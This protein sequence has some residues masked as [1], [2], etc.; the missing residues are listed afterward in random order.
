MNKRED[1]RPDLPSVVG[2]ELSA[3]CFVRDYVELHF[4]GPVLRLLGDVTVKNDSETKSPSD[5]GF[6]DWLCRN[7]GRRVAAVGPLGGNEIELKFHGN[8]IIR[9]EGQN[10]GIGFAQF[11]NFPA[12]RTQV[13]AV[14]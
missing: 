13:W 6:R 8:D 14:D 4:D 2:D 1:H 11:I 5:D 10:L 3:V 9:V 7:I 12:R